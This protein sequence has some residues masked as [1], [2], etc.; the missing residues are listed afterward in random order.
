M[1]STELDVAWAVSGWEGQTVNDS[2]EAVTMYDQDEAEL[3]LS[4]LRTAVND[5][6]EIQ[7]QLENLLLAVSHDLRNPITVVMGHAQLLDRLLERSGVRDDAG[8][9]R[10]IVTMARRMDM[11]V[12]DLVDGARLKS[13][14]L[15][16][17]CQPVELGRFLAELLRRL[18]TSLETGRVR[19]SVAHDARP[20]LADPDRLER[21]VV[22]LLSNALKYS[23]PGTPVQLR[24]MAG[25]GE[26]LI[27][28]EDEGPGIPPEDLPHIFE[29][30]YRGRGPRTGGSAGIGLYAAKVLAE[31]HQ[32]RIRVTSE[33]GKGSTFTV[34]L[35]LA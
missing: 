3:R 34:A 32:G 12:Q 31:A 7:E 9:V 4:E 29:R 1:K 33:P 30:F 28:V 21:I 16:L 35:P 20:A 5:M 24:V 19:L 15:E 17:R 6:V 27:E 14:R 11:M 2:A 26:A 13:G 22:N 25:Q 10:T 23:I 8:S 18:Y